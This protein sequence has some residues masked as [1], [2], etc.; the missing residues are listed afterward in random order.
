MI[1]FILCFCVVL[2]L[3]LNLVI[4]VCYWKEQEKIIDKDVEISRLWDEC[5]KLQIELDEL[6][7]SSKMVD[8]KM[9]YVLNVVG[10]DNE[11]EE[12]LL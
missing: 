1:R 10:N 3:V 7:K 5:H 12:G 11:E 9:N 6:Q 4:L 8:D 2:L